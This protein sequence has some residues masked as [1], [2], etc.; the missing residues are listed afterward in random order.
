M[1]RAPSN[2]RTATAPTK[3]LQ[4]LHCNDTD[5][6]APPVIA[7]NLNRPGGNEQAE[8]RAGNDRGHNNITR[9]SVGGSGSLSGSKK[10]G[11]ANAARC[12]VMEEGL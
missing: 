11:L 10:R 3:H 12:N 1:Q 9:T 8:L 2:L 5:S 4:P 7:L 6:Y